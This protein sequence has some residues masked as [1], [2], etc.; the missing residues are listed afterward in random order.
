MHPPPCGWTTIILAVGSL[1]FCGLAVLAGVVGQRQAR[2]NK[3][4]NGSALEALIFLVA[5]GG[6]NLGLHCHVRHKNKHG[7]DGTSDQRLLQCTKNY[8][9]VLTVITGLAFVMGVLCFGYVRL[10]SSGMSDNKKANFLIAGTCGSI[11]Q[12]LLF[13]SHCFQCKRRESPGTD[14]FGQ[15]MWSRNVG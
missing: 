5:S 10:K 7:E 6:F 14:G 8:L 4:V 2:A 3:G 13:V 1:V 11:F 15:P 9:C 12:A